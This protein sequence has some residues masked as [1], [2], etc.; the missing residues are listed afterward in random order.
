[1]V[2]QQQQVLCLIINHLDYTHTHIGADVTGRLQR[3]TIF[4][5]D[6]DESSPR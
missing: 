1:M 4:E 3:G 5:P 6:G 2:S